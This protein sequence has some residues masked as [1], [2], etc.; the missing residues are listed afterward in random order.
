MKSGMNKEAQ[1]AYHKMIDE[2]AD[3]ILLNVNTVA[4]DITDIVFTELLV[5][6]RQKI[7]GIL[8]VKAE[9]VCE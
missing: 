3:K 1:K 9:K 5:A 7:D 8:A 4:F 2:A 6:I